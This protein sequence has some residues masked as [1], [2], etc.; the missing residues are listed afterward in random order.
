MQVVWLSPTAHIH[1]QDALPLRHDKW[2]GFVPP[3]DSDS[4]V[5]ETRSYGT[6]EG[7]ASDLSVLRLRLR[8]C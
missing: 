2:S 3:D 6:G 4:R 7:F 5:D 8:V 1:Y